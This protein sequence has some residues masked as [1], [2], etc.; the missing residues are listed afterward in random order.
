M[1]FHNT[2]QCLSS[3]YHQNT[4]APQHMRIIMIDQLKT[5]M[6][7]HYVL[8]AARSKFKLLAAAG[9][10]SDWLLPMHALKNNGILK[11]THFLKIIKVCMLVYDWAYKLTNQKVPCYLIYTTVCRSANTCLIINALKCSSWRW[12]PL[13]YIHKHTGHNCMH[14]YAHSIVYTNYCIYVCNYV[15]YTMAEKFVR[16]ETTKY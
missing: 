6:A 11:H 1:A 4:I 12:K 7:Q 10:I 8:V 16:H 9:H 14:A 5:N 13:N 3:N 15:L 2:K